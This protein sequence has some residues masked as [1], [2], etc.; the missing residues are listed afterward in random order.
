LKN[1]IKAAEIP[2]KDEAGR[3]FDF[4]SLRVQYG[5]ILAQAG[6][7]IRTAMEM[8]RHTDIRLTTQVYTDPKLLNTTSAAR[9]LPRLGKTQKAKIQK[10]TGT[11]GNAGLLS[12]L[13][14]NLTLNET[15]SHHLAL[16]RA[17]IVESTGQC[18]SLEMLPVSNDC[19]QKNTACHRTGNKGEAGG[20]NWGTR[21]RT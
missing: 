20:K 13:L 8:M 11:D 9:S 15:K 17:D 4:H 21:I 3:Q 5:T 1:Q 7:N 2:Y 10:A 16:S 19:H 14:E 12:G 18:K 6:V